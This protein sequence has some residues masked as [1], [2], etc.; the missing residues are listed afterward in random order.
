MTP[1]ERIEWE[2]RGFLVVPEALDADELAQIREAAAS[3]EARWRRDP[4]L[5]GARGENLEQVQAPI[6]Y[7]DRL[8]ALLWHPKTFPLVR[9]A[10]GGRAAMIDNDFFITPPHAPQTHADWH[11]D[12]GM[13]GVY[14]PR[15]TL[16]VKVFFLMSDVGEG[17]GGTAMIPGSHRFPN[18]WQFPRVDDPRAMP[19]AIQMLGKAGTAYIFNGR[20]FHC[21]VRNESDQ[22]RRV[23]I[24]NYGHPW[25][26]FWPGYE[27]SE[28][29]LDIARA[30]GDP[31]QKELLGLTPCY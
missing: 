22:A 26:R 29:L 14:H 9:E 11:H 4:A 17:A 15:S 18:E 28:R 23:L 30:S 13:A 12:V 20:I 25:M 7:D 8:L 16:M 27:P 5:A 10:L 1:T 2:S 19:G 3:A 21:A 24:Y 31:A 6:E